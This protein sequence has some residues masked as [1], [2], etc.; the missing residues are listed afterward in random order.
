MSRSQ[1]QDSSVGRLATMCRLLARG[2]RQRLAT[3]FS[4]LPLS[5]PTET[6]FGLFTRSDSAMGSK[7]V[8]NLKAQLR[9]LRGRTMRQV[10]D[11]SS[12]SLATPTGRGYTCCVMLDSRSTAVTFLSSLFF[13]FVFVGLAQ[14]TSD[15]P[16]NHYGV[17]MGLVL[18]RFGG[19]NHVNNTRS[20][21]SFTHSLSI[22][23]SESV[24]IVLTIR[25]LK[26]LRGQCPGG[27]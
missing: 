25:D 23:H 18:S 15:R 26:R 1:A 3:V 22:I 5:R 21:S 6:P 2:D 11:K 17:P 13:S 12:V 24:Q 20:N 10:A 19:I 16:S 8:L 27:L 7:V 9:I 14:C 4:G